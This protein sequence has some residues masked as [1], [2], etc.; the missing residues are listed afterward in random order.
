M[1]FGNQA[2]SFLGINGRY[3]GNSVVAVA[4]TPGPAQLIAAWI[5]A[6]AASYVAPLYI[7]NIA[8]VA[9][10]GKLV[11][12]NQAALTGRIF[13]S[14]LIDYA[15]AGSCSWRWMFTQAVIPATAFGVAATAQCA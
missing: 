5:T 2:H 15:F 12:I 8:S 4:L 13:I 7:S 1:E 3:G 9:I 14:Y 10:R 6:G 11:S